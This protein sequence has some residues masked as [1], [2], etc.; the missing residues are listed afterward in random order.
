MSERRWDFY[1]R[2]ML[3]CCRK[4][5]DYVSGLDHAVFSGGRSTRW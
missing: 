4:V 5:T 1:V 2:D 3:E